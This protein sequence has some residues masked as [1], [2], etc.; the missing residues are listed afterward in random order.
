[1]AGTHVLYS[2]IS[3][4]IG[5]RKHSFKNYSTAIG[6]LGKY[7]TKGEPSF[8]GGIVYFNSLRG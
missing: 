1:M 5:Y 3:N 2:S 4:G 7:S 6:R 8:A